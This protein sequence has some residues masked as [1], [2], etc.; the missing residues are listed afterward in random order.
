MKGWFEIASWAPR[1]R[2]ILVWA[3][4]RDGLPAM[5]SV[6]RWHPDAGYCI[7]EI[8]EPTYWRELPAPPG[9]SSTEKAWHAAEQI[10]ATMRKEPDE[11]SINYVAAVIYNLLR[12]VTPPS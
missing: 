6:C 11:I 3:P 12:K 5:Y 7:D 1:D 4:A 10:V 8:R 2:E 9:A